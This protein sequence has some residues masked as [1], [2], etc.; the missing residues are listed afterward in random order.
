MKIDPTWFISLA[1]AAQAAELT[2]Q[3][4][5]AHIFLFQT[6]VK[7]CDDGKHSERP[8][9]KNAKTLFAKN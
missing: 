1:D 7:N 4:A 3:V 6:T 5:K 8:E 9:L 2:H